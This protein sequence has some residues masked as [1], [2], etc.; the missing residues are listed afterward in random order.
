VRGRSHVLSALTLVALTATATAQPSP[1]STQLFDEGRALARQQQWALACERFSQSLA[2]DPAPGTKLNLGDC[3]E[4]QGKVHA[5]WLMF[6]DAARDFDRLSDTRA[7]FARNRAAAAS[8]R[9]ATLVI[10]VAASSRAGLAI[11]IGDRAVTPEPE[12]VLRVDP[13][14][15]VV[16]VTVP[17][18]PPFQATVAALAGRSVVIEVPAFPTRPPPVEPPR[19]TRKVLAIGLGAAG[20]GCLVGS[21]ILGLVAKRQY[22]G[23]F[24]DGACTKT[25][26]GNVCSPSG[27][28]AIDRAGTKADVGTGFLIAG[29]ALAITGVVVYVTSPTRHRISVSPMATSS[30][31][32]VMLGGRF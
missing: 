10:K 27:K 18:E 16:T 23:A 19:K 25:D 7:A 15:Q 9:L 14:T 22:D 2:L 1:A 4:N 28:R 13:G 30:T 3:L 26:A 31:A 24:D 17:G 6:E 29:A 32:G 5:A 21:G 12:V 8:L 20:A 11:R